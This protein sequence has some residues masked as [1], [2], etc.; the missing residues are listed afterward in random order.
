MADFTG[1]PNMVLAS[2]TETE[3][4][5]MDTPLAPQMIF[6]TTTGEVNFYDGTEWRKF[7]TQAA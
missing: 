7:Q 4:D 1:S 6:N 3:R 2:M 5:A